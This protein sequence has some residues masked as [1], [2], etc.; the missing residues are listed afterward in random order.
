MHKYF[1]TEE[2]C[3]IINGADI[4]A[5]EIGGFP[6]MEDGEL[7]QFNFEKAFGDK[8]KD[9]LTLVYDIRG[10]HKNCSYYLDLR[11]LKH[12]KIMMVFEGRLNVKYISDNVW[13]EIKFGNNISIMAQDG[14]PLNINVVKRPFTCFCM[15]DKRNLCVDFFEE[16]CL[17]SAKLL[18]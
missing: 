13:G 8:A 18:R 14:D 12:T 11:P 3:S 2:E 4:I 7:L 17:I 15:R 1:L 9:R 5:D 10:W 6:S 16:D